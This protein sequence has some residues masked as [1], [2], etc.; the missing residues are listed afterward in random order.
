[1]RHTT[2]QRNA[3]TLIELLVVIAII[4]IL[5]G[6]LLPALAK[7]KA[8]AQ[9][10]SC[11]NNLKQIGLSY[12]M[13]SNEHDDRFPWYVAP[14]AG[15][16]MTTA[17]DPFSGALV[18]KFRSISNEVNSPKPLTCPSDGRSKAS[19]WDP[20]VTGG[21]ANTGAKDN[22][23][24]FVGIDADETKP[25]S[26]LSGDRNL[27][28][29]GG[30]QLEGDVSLDGPATG[31]T[32]TWMDIMHNKGGN[33]GLGDGSAQQTSSAGLQKQVVSAVQGGSGSGGKIRLQIPPK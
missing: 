24:Y 17:G 33:L 2:P 6:L 9:R 11:V 28:N 29:A 32:D 16:T 18:D 10:I 22:I 3:F 15:G 31:N 1:M 30:T 12:R 21:L 20:G 13:W 26:I 27:Q 14:N 7:A 25:Q 19:S 23:S 8:R 4:A 5:A